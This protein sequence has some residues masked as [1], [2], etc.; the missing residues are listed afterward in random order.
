MAMEKDRCRKDGFVTLHTSVTNILWKN[1]KP[2][3]DELA[4]FYPDLK[5]IRSVLPKLQKSLRAALGSKTNFQVGDK[6]AI[7]K[8]HPGIKFTIK[9]IQPDGKLLLTH[10]AKDKNTYE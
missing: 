2:N 3:L 9:E 7:D 1:I 4:F 8:E 10:I 5:N 6:V